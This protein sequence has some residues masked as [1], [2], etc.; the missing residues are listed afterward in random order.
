MLLTLSVFSV[1]FLKCLIPVIIPPPI[2]SVLLEK[3]NNNKKNIILVWS[4]LSQAN[5]FLKLNDHW[6]NA[7]TYI[8]LLII[9]AVLPI[10]LIQVV[11]QSS[12]ESFTH[13]ISSK[14]T[15]CTHIQWA[16]LAQ[17]TAVKK[18]RENV[19]QTSTKCVIYLCDSD[20]N[21]KENR[22]SIVSTPLNSIWDGNF[23]HLLSFPVL[24][25]KTGF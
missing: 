10:S 7:Q 24:A 12:F 17:H 4:Y 9:G 23:Q 3:N 8:V 18:D 14:T 15:L 16:H 6:H 22:T 1:S 5:S 11:P 20:L 2:I 13:F 19:K 21:D 25:F